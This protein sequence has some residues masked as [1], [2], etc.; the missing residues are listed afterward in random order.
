[1][2]K[3]DIVSIPR[4]SPSHNHGS[5]QTNPSVASR[6]VS[7]LTLQHSCLFRLFHIHGFTW[8]PMIYSPACPSFMSRP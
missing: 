1:M 3:T 7:T 5:T 4:Q 6:I 8:K 2:T